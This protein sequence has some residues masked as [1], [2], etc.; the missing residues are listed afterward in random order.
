MEKVIYQAYPHFYNR[1][2]EFV[3]ENITI[4]N[5]DVCFV[6]DSLTEMMDVSYFKDLKCVNRGIVSD[7]S[8]GILMTLDDR[9]IKTN[10]KTIFM[11]IGS[12][13]ICD[14][15]TIKQIEN[16]IKD[17]IAYCKE[18]LPN[19]NF[20]ISTV[21]PP[22][23]YQANHV[24]QI[25]PECRD[26]LR[27]KALNEVILSLQDIKNNVKVFDGYSILA[28]KNDSLELDDTLDGVHL[29]KKAY[30]KLQSKIIEIL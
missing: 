22:C 21:L 12:N 8:A 14:G 20:I 24:E 19:V 2:I 5:C 9:V 30:E 28:D 16:N 11:L 29:T 27:I 26:I 25:Y 7:K 15:Y 18:K 13:D 3:N 10:P 6:G 4:K 23:Y 1:M 17:I